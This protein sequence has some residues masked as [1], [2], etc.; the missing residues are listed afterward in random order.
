MALAPGTIVEGSSDP[1]TVEQNAALRRMQTSNGDVG[2]QY[3]GCI[4]LPDGTVTRDP[5]VI[6]VPD[7]RKKEVSDVLNAA[8]KL[9]ADGKTKSGGYLIFL[10]TAGNP[11]QYYGVS[12]VNVQTNADQAFNSTLTPAQQSAGISHRAAITLA[13]SG[14]QTDGT[15]VNDSYLALMEKWADQEGITFYRPTAAAIAAVNR[16]APA[17]V[18]VTSGQG[19]AATPVPSVITYAHPQQTVQVESPTFTQ[20][21]IIS[22]EFTPPAALTKPYVK[23]VNTTAQP[24]LTAAD[25]T[26]AP[27]TD[28]A[29]DASVAAAKNRTLYIVGG[30]ILV[31]AALS[32]AGGKK[33]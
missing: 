18:V 13:M 22:E 25:S 5:G 12:A 27:T 4:V 28:P 7:A 29:L 31:L 33:S 30:I 15:P 14:V 21:A 9:N 19:I 24:T 8:G 11:V 6:V 20:G 2:T 16:P 17:A 3:A 32:L 26:T 1:R 23:M 10:N